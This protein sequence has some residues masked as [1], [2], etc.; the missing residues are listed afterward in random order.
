MATATVISLPVARVF[1][2]FQRFI[3]GGLTAG[4]VKG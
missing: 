1:A 2:T 4:T 3:V